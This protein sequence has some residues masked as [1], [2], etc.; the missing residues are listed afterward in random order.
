MASIT[1]PNAQVGPELTPLESRT[2]IAAAVA[3]EAFEPFIAWLVDQAVLDSMIERGVLEAGPSCRPSVGKTGYRLTSKGWQ[4]WK[5]R[6]QLNG[7][8]RAAM[9]STTTRPPS[10]SRTETIMLG[11][12]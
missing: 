6:N 2:L 3:A 10:S 4:C 11:D 9:P 12:V 8:I 7:P 1:F 5:Q